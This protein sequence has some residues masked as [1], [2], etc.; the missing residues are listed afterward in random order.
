MILFNEL[1]NNGGQEIS[2][3]LYNITLF[4]FVSFYKSVSFL[5]MI[6]L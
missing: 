6:L 4:L 5:C 2:I 1:Y 3:F